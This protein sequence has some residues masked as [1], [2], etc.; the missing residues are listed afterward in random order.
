MKIFPL[1]SQEYEFD[2]IQNEL[3]WKLAIKMR[4]FAYF[5]TTMGTFALISGI[6]F[7]FIQGKGGNLRQLFLGIFM[8]TRELELAPMV[9]FV[10]GILV[11]SI[12]IIFIGKSTAQAAVK[13]GNVA[14]T[15]GNDMTHL[16]A[17][18]RKLDRVCSLYYQLAALL[19]VAIWINIIFF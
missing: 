9:K 15:D 8:G 6:A 4:N 3:L 17:A 16:M 10:V 7:L 2:S 13:L 19:V 14:N 18:L 5:W 11:L 1:K 12:Y